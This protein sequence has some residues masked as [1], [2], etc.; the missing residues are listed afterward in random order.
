MAEPATPPVRPW[1]RGLVFLLLAAY[2]LVDGVMWVVGFFQLFENH[3][4]SS[5]WW[6]TGA[7]FLMLLVGWQWRWWVAKGWVGGRPTARFG[8][9]SKG[10]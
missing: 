7:L 1:P 8:G 5:G 9:A 4:A 3:L 6:L 2:V 10:D